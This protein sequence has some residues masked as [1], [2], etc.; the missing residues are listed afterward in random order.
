MDA[1]VAIDQF[2]EKCRE[3]LD[4]NLSTDGNGEYDFTEIKQIINPL[5]HAVYI[6]YVKDR[7]WKSSLEKTFVEDL[8]IVLSNK[9]EQDIDDIDEELEYDESATQSPLKP[10]QPQIKHSVSMLQ[11]QM[12]GI[13]SAGTFLVFFH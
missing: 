9:N 10:N 3:T 6:K 7:N 1:I 5:V 4:A 13:E 11:R 8:C 2:K 12:T